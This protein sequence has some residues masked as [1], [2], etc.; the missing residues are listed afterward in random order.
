MAKVMIF[1]SLKPHLRNQSGVNSFTSGLLRWLSEQGAPDGSIN[2]ESHPQGWVRLDL[3]PIA[4][5]AVKR[6]P[7]IHEVGNVDVKTRV[8]A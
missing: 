6:H 3:S 5:E 1:V 4:A 8:A 7:A 2:I